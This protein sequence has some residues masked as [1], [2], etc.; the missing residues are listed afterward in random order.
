M[1]YCGKRRDVVTGTR[2]R[3]PGRSPGTDE[4][5]G[6]RRDWRPGASI[7]ALRLRARVLR[8]VRAHFDAE[9]VLE[10]ET[11]S[12]GSR[13]VTDPSI[14]SLVARDRAGRAW[15]LQTSPEFAMKRLLAAGSGSIY[16]I[17]RAF[18]DGERGR[19]HNHEFSMLEWYRVGF[20]HHRLIDDVDALLD[21]VLGPGPSR[22]MTFRDAF[23]SHLG[24]DPLTAPLADLHDACRS[25]GFESSA[26]G[27]VRDECLDWLL[28]AAVQPA[29]GSGRVYLLDFPAS[30][31]A[32]A[33]VR[34]DSPPVAERFELYIDGIEVANG[35]HELRDA[36]E[37]H[38]R[39]RRD[40]EARSAAEQPVPEFDDRL[41]A[42]HE[43]GLPACAGVAVGLDRLVMLAGRYRSLQEVLAFAQ[44]TA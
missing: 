42:A 19:H 34:T 9:G 25:H 3:T 40:I 16:Q 22:R 26:A 20:D 10:V 43:A 7:G 17:T 15:Y 30:R 14:E 32:L 8:A 4:P 1:T 36:G 29:L 13:T 5:A 31:A 12:L 6:S 39:M 44:D 27:A 18:R 38:R 23:S 35:Y 21:T 28:S 2:E 37:L 41:L 11:P 33:R 24:L